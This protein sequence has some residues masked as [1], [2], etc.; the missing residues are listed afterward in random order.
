MKKTLAT[1]GLAV[2]IS[3]MTA[4]FGLAEYA[5]SGN[6]N[7]PFFHLGALIVGGIDHYFSPG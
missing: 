5:V 6:Q 4:T 7:F 3:L 1:I 2:F